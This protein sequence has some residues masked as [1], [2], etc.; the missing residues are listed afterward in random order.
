MVVMMMNL[1]KWDLS[2]CFSKFAMKY[3][4]KMGQKKPKV[5]L[6]SK[7]KRINTEILPHWALILIEKR[8]Q[9]LP[10]ELGL[11]FWPTQLQC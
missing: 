6:F 11:P 3:K 9:V 4:N 8:T 5:V 1:A 2:G 7:Q 10:L